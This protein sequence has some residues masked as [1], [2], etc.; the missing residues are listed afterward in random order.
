[1][2]V[3]F[4]GD[5]MGKSGRTA[6]AQNLPRIRE[7]VKP[8][9][10][11]ANAE[12]AAGGAGMTDKTCEELFGYGID[13]LTGGN[14]SWDKMDIVDYIKGESRLLRPLNFPKNTPGKGYHIY[15]ASNGQ[16]IMVINL[17]GQLFMDS[18]NNPFEAVEE[19]LSEHFLKANV[20]FIFVDIH[21]ETTS[22]K[23]AMAFMLDSRVSCVVGTHTHIPTADA[24]IL[25][26]GTAYQTDAGMCGD[27]NSVIGVVPETTIPRF[28][29]KMRSG[30]I[31]FAKGPG[32]MCGIIVDTDDST[33]L[34]TSIQPLRVGHNLINTH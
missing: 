14:H 24:Q 12:N 26:G 17:I 1:M 13:V 33:G 9:F 7:E 4:L 19:V 15:R 30:R 6:I 27:Y 22:E 21:G 34:A 2:R 23:M 8:D 3:I 25:P 18:Y 28:A 10:I 32:T 20:D 29:T 11:I 31:E 16:R 5:I